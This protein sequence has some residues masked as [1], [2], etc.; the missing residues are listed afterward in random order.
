MS[1]GTTKTDPATES[2]AQ[3]ILNTPFVGNIKEYMAKDI[4]KEDHLKLLQEAQK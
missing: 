3:E 2:F 4:M 1:Y